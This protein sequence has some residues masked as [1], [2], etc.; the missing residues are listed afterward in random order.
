MISVLYYKAVKRRHWHSVAHFVCVGVLGASTAHIRF[1]APFDINKAKG[2]QLSQM[3]II[4]PS[5][6]YLPKRRDF[7]AHEHIYQIDV[8]DVDLAVAI[9]VR[10]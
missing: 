9:D 7:A 2:A 4:Y 5:G 3:T 6:N 10:D 8:A 1:S